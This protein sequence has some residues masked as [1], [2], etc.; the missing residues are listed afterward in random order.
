M[1]G[2]STFVRLV[3]HDRL[4]TIGGLIV[5]CVLAW[6]YLFAGAGMGMSLWR[7][8]ALGFTPL[9]HG[10]VPAATMAQMPMDV[11]PWGAGDW[12]LMIAMWWVMMVA[13]MTPSAAPA[14][15]LYAQVHQHALT[16]G[17]APH[18]HA[19]T[20]LFASGYFLAWLGFS[21]AA[22]ALQQVLELSGV[23]SAMTMGSQVRW[24]SGALLIGAGAY[25]LSS[26][27]NACLAHCR[28]PASFLS[29]HWRPHALGAVRLGAL[30]GAYCV[31]CCWMLMVLLFV[32][33]VMNLVWIAALSLLVLAEKLL[34][35]GRW[36]GHATGVV[37][38]AWGLAVLFA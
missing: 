34:R 29:Q 27:K 25:Q 19:P 30:H 2:A 32:G 8:T 17:H 21:I 5:L 35:R 6:A 38:V 9:P 7:M 12:L 26:I 20:G 10:A 14:I 1:P 13:M 23:L 37:L 15:L 33:G 28:S 16:Q 24:V 31:G 4:I 11:S 22:T 36:V 3:R 18:L